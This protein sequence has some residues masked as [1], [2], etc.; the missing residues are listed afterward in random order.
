MLVSSAVSNII[1]CLVFGDRYEY[2]D[3]QYQ[4]IL[5]DFSDL[6]YLEGS[7][8]AQVRISPILKKRH[9]DGLCN[10]EHRLEVIHEAH[11]PDLI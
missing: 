3:K 5:Q 10:T 6:V 4:S 1:C 2:D 11:R 9:C 8:W 7:V